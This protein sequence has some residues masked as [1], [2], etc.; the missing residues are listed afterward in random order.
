MSLLVGMLLKHIVCKLVTIESELFRFNIPMNLLFLAFVLVLF[1]FYKILR[2]LVGK[3]RVPIKLDVFGKFVILVTILHLAS[4]GASSFIEEEHQLWYYISQTMFIILFLKQLQTH[5]WHGKDFI[6]FKFPRDVEKMRKKGD[7]KGEEQLLKSIEKCHNCV[8]SFLLLIVTHVICRRLNQTGDKWSHLRD[9]GDFFAEEENKNFLTLLVVPSMI[10]ICC[11]L[12][13]LGGLLT[14]ILTF[15]ALL[16]VFFYR[17]SM[18][19]LLVFNKVFSSPRMPVLLFWLNVV[20]IILIEFLPFFYR[21]LI[22]R[23]V[24]RIELGRF[25][26]SLVTVFTVVS[27]LLH[28][29]H[30]VVLVP[31]CVLTCRWIKGK[32]FAIWSGATER[33]IFILATHFWIGKM[34]FFYQVRGLVVAD[35]SWTGLVIPLELLTIFQGNSNSLATIDLNAGYIGLEAYH[36]FVVGFCITLNTFSGPI[37]AFLLALCHVFEQA[38]EANVTSDQLHKLQ[39][40]I[41]VNLLRVQSVQLGLPL[42]V[43][44][45]VATLFRNHLFVWTVFS[46][47]LIYELYSFALYVT[48]WIA[49]YGWTRITSKYAKITAS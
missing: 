1:Y 5:A 31:V 14:N 10:L 2:S 9:I 21:A 33:T 8:L 30:N 7:V 34:F 19:Q 39:T 26:G 32:V 29:P 16:L 35:T 48:L 24:N 38:C 44:L 18:G 28:K 45:I 49:F 46:P 25:M 4:L 37:L 11:S 36:P 22:Q 6:L 40:T 47:K 3:V 17:S 12:H 42:T 23:T 20:E 41:S 27:V 15:T 43:Y 13:S